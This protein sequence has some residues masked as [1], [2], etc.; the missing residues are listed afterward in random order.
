L[1]SR[2]ARPKR[3]LACVSH[4]I[5]QGQESLLVTHVSRPGWAR[6]A[7]AEARGAS[8][9]RLVLALPQGCFIG[10]RLRSAACLPG[11]SL[12]RQP[13]SILE[14][15]QLRQGDIVSS[16]SASG[17]VCFWGRSPGSGS[18]LLYLSSCK[19][20]ALLSLPSGCSLRLRAASQARLGGLSM[21]DHRLE[22]RA[23]GGFSRREGFR[24]HV[25]GIAKNPVDHPNGGRSNSPSPSMSP[26]GW[27]AKKGR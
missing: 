16:L 14:L 26:W 17:R 6:A 24:P 27:V 10:T 8:G 15:A 9:S 20:F 23:S 4:R 2:A 7:V 22:R 25:R 19:K 1:S 11:S 12:P 13:G 21:R 5:S 3:R 18:R